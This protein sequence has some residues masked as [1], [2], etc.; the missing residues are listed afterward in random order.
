MYE[1]IFKESCDFVSTF[2]TLYIEVDVLLKC[3]VY[4]M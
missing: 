2:C 3:I 1:V 4:E